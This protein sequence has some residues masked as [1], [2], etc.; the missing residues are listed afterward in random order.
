[1]ICFRRKSILR[2]HHL[3][4][5]FAAEFFALRYPRRENAR[6]GAVGGWRPI[7]LRWAL[8]RKRASKLLNN[9]A[10]P[11]SFVS[12]SQ[13][14]HF[15]LVSHFSA[16]VAT[17]PVSDKTPAA[18]VAPPLRVLSERYWNTITMLKTRMKTGK[19]IRA[20]QKVFAYSG[21]P[22]EK[23][24]EVPYATILQTSSAHQKLASQAQGPRHKVSGQISGIGKAQK[25]REMTVRFSESRSRMWQRYDQFFF[26][27][28][29]TTEEQTTRVV[30]PTA[31]ARQR[32]L[33]P[34]ELAW[35]S[36][37]PR[38]SR[39]KG[40]TNYDEPA[41]SRDHTEPRSQSAPVPGPGAAQNF[42]TA[43]PTKLSGFDPAIMDRLADN[44]IERVE[45]KMRIERQRRGL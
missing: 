2:M 16:P 28:R 25:V 38:L 39:G 13:N 9:Q 45:K 14:S 18:T 19:D 5:R 42:E 29:K 23:R 31:E 27:Y 12:V 34:E 3:A 21:A 1:M 36:Q 6:G 7:F 32:S 37:P 30:S 33:R 17:G 20:G 43:I 24:Q 4:A 8:R 44:V 26:R 10:A 15:R 41:E 40:E 35:R 11:R 22:P